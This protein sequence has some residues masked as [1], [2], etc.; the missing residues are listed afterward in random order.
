LSTAPYD[1]PIIPVATLKIKVFPAAFWQAPVPSAF[2][3][4]YCHNSPACEAAS[5]RS[6][7]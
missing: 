6:N 2:A 5:T 1:Q 4:G 7:P 3:F